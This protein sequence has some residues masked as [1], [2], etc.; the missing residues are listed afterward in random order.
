MKKASLLVSILITFVVILLLLGNRHISTE[1]TINAPVDAVWAELMDFPKYPE[2]N[3]FITK[4]SGEMKKGSTIEVTFHTKGSDPMVFTPEIL[5]N[6]AN[7]LFQWQGR[8]L[9]PGIFTGRHT[10]QLEKIDAGKTKLVQKE[11]FNGILV[12]FFN[13]NST[14]EGFTLMNEALKKRVEGACKRG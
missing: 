3:P 9:M 10:F 6:D 11:N 5:V 2:W 4:V 12:P 13:F 1:I 8:L 7:S 14:I